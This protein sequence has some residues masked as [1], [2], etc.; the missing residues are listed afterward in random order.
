MNSVLAGS[1]GGLAATLPMTWTMDRLHRR[2]PERER[3][4]MHPRL[5]TMQVARKAGVLHE[6]DESEQFGLT[7]AAHFAYG[8]LVGALY[9][10]LTHPIPG[11]AV[12]KGAAYGLAVWAGN[13][14]GLLPALGILSPAT[15]H[16]PRRTA[17]MIAA[18]LVWGM[19]AGM[20]TDCLA[21]PP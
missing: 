10:P 12:V 14:L 19:T 8:A 2:L 5:V 9:G 1:V 13:Y 17:I 7:L 3:Y 16:P 6:L 20:V 11:P 4:P 18:H 21:A 15:D